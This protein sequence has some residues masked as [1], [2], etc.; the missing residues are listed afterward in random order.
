MT[1]F[2]FAA[3]PRQQKPVL[4]FPRE[5]RKNCRATIYYKQCIIHFSKLQQVA[6]FKVSPVGE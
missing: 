1:T 2:Q 3:V 6:K 4:G 5:C